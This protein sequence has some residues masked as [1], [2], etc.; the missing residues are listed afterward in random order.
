MSFWFSLKYLWVNKIAQLEDI[1][2][3]E[4]MVKNENPCL[5]CPRTYMGKLC[6]NKIFIRRPRGLDHAILF[7]FF[8]PSLLRYFPRSRL[9]YFFFFFYYTCNVYY[10]ISQK[11]HSLFFPFFRILRGFEYYYR[12]TYTYSLKL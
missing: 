7:S 10:I 4:N 9:F 1:N 11:C 12:E 8:L 2:V 3:S 6:T 5:A